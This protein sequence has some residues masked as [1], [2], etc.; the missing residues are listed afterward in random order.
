MDQDNKIKLLKLLDEVREKI[1]NDDK[2]DE[3]DRVNIGGLFF[4]SW[5]DLSIIPSI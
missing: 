2:K 4:D 5:V 1:V 3:S